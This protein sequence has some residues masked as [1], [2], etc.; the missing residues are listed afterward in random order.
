M[1]L[2]KISGLSLL[3]GLTLAIAQPADRVLMRV[4]DQQLSSPAVLI[5]YGDTRF[6]DT[7]ETFA[8][9]PKVRRWL[10]DQIALEKP[11][12]IIMSG[13]IPWHGQE[14]N[15]YAVFAA[16]TKPWRDAGILVSAALGNHE[17]NGPDQKQ[18]L[19]NW[20]AAFPKLRGHRWYAAAIGSKVLVLNLDSTSPLTH[21]SEQQ[22]WIIDELTHLPREVR[23]VLFNMHHPPVADLDPAI[24][25]DHNARPNEIALATL[26]KDSPARK[27]VA[28]VVLAGH[29]HN[30]ERFLQDGITYLVSGGGGATPK[31]TQRDGRDLYM[32]PSAV[33]YHYVRLLLQ[34]DK[35][36]AEMI[37]V[38]EPSASVPEWEVRDRFEVKAP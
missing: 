16:E 11:A 2:L 7:A 31:L 24:D 13:D 22:R 23:Y 36:V 37:R 3:A 27:Q 5:A 19:E 29:I 21:G 26:L 10:T 15:D 33:N 38:A 25:A 6:T 1:H 18:C 9:N 14:K 34:E 30:Y 28:F 8:S 32:F 17:L 35:L 20:W 4:P 12:A